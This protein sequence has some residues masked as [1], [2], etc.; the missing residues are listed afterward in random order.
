MSLSRKI[1]NT[2]ETLGAVGL[3]GLAG[4]GC[5]EIGQHMDRPLPVVQ[6]SR[7]FF[8]KEPCSMVR[9]YTTDSTGRDRF[10]VDENGDGQADVIVFQNYVN[11]IAEGHKTDRWTI[12]ETKTMTPEIRDAATK[13]LKSDQDLAF[14]LNQRAYQLD[15]NKE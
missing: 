6:Y 5:W 1:G 4:K 11:W 3:I 8:S 10:I 14:L 12:P 7:D 15:Q 2:L 9:E 13:A